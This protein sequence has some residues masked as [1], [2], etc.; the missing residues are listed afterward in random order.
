M[1]D[2]LVDSGVVGTDMGLGQLPQP[3]GCSI[4]R[5]SQHSAGSR[6][7]EL[8]RNRLKSVELGQE[9]DGSSSI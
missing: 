4:A 7:A 8:N 9:E 6:Q 5:R 3:V 2:K 1:V